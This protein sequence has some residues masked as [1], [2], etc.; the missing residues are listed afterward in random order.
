MSE[1]IEKFKGESNLEHTAIKNDVVFYPFFLSIVLV[2]HND[3]KYLELI[4]SDLTGLIEKR[5]ADYEIIVVDNGSN[6]ASLSILKSLT[7]QRGLA[8]LQ[9][10]SLTKEVDSDTAF[11]VG[12]E[13]SLGD[14]VVMLDPMVDDIHSIPDM[15]DCIAGGVDVVFA[16]STSKTPPSFSY[17][18]LQKLFNGLY[19]KLNGI[20][21][22]KDAPQYR[23]LSRKVINF[24][25]QHPRPNIA[26]RHLPVTGGFQRANINCKRSSKFNRPIH[27]G[28]AI[29]RAMYLIV[30]TTN[31]PMR[32]VTSLCILGAAS[33]VVYSFYVVIIAIF[34]ED[35]AAGWVSL[36][37]QQSGMFFLISLVLLVL[38]EYIL[39]AASVSNGGPLYHIAHE[40]SSA[41]MTRN[42]KLNIELSETSFFKNNQ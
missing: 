13:N 2:V 4:I 28:D 20:N 5:A 33:N 32:L 15:L 35:V 23:L 39:N 9:V 11:W 42:E 30:S 8:N 7:G 25:L 41:R 29:N 31:L 1:L 18:F 40:F 21:L 27:F 34:K 12:L 10:F 24:I 36:S 14:F 22:Q 19:K 16:Q 38:A 26:C 3:A 17:V 37:L 6:D